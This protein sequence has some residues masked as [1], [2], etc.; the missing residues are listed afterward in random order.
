MENNDDQLASRASR[1]PTLAPAA[2]YRFHLAKGHRRRLMRKSKPHHPHALPMHDCDRH[3]LP[4]PCPVCNFSQIST[5]DLPLSS[6]LACSGCK[7]EKKNRTFPTF[8]SGGHKHRKARSLR[9]VKV[10]YWWYVFLL[11]IFCCCLFTLSLPP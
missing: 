1:A 3:I 4:V 6:L 8:V 9:K 5:A 11:K 10:A 2:L 7:K